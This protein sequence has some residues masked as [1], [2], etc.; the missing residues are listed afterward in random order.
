MARFIVR[1]ELYNATSEDYENLNTHMADFGLGRKIQ[2]ANHVLYD[3][4]SAEFYG[5]S[6][7]T[8][9]DILDDAK[10]A[11]AKVKPSFAVL[12]TESVAS[13]WYNLPPSK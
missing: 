4:P 1:V 9:E 8:R 7:A 5:E 2:N 12:V 6:A 13:A 3:L 11:A 10:A